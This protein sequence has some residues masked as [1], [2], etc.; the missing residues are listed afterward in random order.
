MNANY[1]RSNHD[2]HRNIWAFIP[3]I[4]EIPEI[5]ICFGFD[6]VND[7]HILRCNN[8]EATLFSQWKKKKKISKKTFTL[9]KQCLSRC[10]KTYNIDFTSRCVSLN[11][12]P[13]ACGDWRS[14]WNN[15][16]QTF[17]LKCYWKKNLRKIP[18]FNV[19]NCSIA[20]KVDTK[21]NKWKWINQNNG[22][23]LTIVMT[24]NNYTYC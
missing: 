3:A 4:K 20:L 21:M 24:W 6:Q 18:T 5:S 14:I 19:F 1:H 8:W 2:G 10:R 12:L 11:I 22:T 13:V 23:A 9:S 16:D 15:G 7:I 17:L